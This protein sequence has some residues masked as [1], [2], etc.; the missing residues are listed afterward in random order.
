M[1]AKFHDHT[2]VVLY[3]HRKYK[4]IY[5]VIAQGSLLLV[6]SMLCC[7]DNDNFGLNLCAKFHD[8]TRLITTYSI[9]IN[10]KFTFTN[11]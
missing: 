10:Y 6:T 1:C 11:L 9:N 8:H 2:Y 5:V 7:H 4:V 3:A